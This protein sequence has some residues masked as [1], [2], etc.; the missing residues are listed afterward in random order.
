MCCPEFFFFFYAR[1]LPEYINEK[2]S[3]TRHGKITCTTTTAK[4][5]ETNKQTVR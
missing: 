5:N 4:N 1:N 2:L 3:G